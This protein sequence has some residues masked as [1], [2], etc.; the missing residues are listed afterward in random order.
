M[1]NTGVVRK[2]DNLGRIVIPIEIR[3]NL[4]MEV[5]D[6]V[7]FYIDGDFI[8]IKRYLKSCP[9]CNKNESEL[10]AGKIIKKGRQVICRNCLNALNLLAENYK[11]I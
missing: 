3:R 2:I 4:N 6:P 10:E 8:L 7:Q 5:N 9:Y 1:K 11:E